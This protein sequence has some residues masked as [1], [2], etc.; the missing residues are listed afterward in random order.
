[1]PASAGTNEKLKSFAEESIAGKR[2]LHTDAAVITPAAKPS[3]AHSV[4]FRISFFIKN[5]QADPSA[6]PNSGNNTP[7]KIFCITLYYIKKDLRTV[8]PEGRL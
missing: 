2:R 7:K 6:V 8:Q 3:S 4:L 5:A 1:M